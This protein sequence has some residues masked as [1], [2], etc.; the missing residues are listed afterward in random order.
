[1]TKNPAKRLGCVLSQGGEDAIRAHPFFKEMDWEALENRQMKPPFKPK[2]VIK[3]WKV[4]VIEQRLQKSINSHVII[5][6]SKS[7]TRSRLKFKCLNPFVEE[8]AGHDQLW[9]RLHERRARFDAHCG[10]C[11][12]HYKSGRV[13]RL[14]LCQP[15][16]QGAVLT[17]QTNT[18]FLPSSE[19]KKH[20]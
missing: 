13:P 10:R 6:G 4:L 15:E 8:Q 11:H 2:I 1:M 14:R 12:T 3:P 7:I 5:E 20:K 9:R 18:V 16:L 19:E 17:L